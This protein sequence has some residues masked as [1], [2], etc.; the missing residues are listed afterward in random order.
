MG[1]EKL[2]S[3][4]TTTATQATKAPAGRRN[5]RSVPTVHSSEPLFL[6]DVKAEPAKWSQEGVVVTLKRLFGWLPDSEVNALCIS[7]TRD[8]KTRSRFLCG[9]QAEEYKQSQSHPYFTARDP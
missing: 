8:R 3:T 2:F 7:L 6:Y 5:D 4:S 1:M 9:R